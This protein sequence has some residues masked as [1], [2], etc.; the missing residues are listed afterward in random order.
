MVKNEQTPTEI[1]AFMM[2]ETMFSHFFNVDDC[3]C[4]LNANPSECVYK[5]VKS[6]FSESM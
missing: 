2:K 1:K 4:I 5:E 3:I 6:Y